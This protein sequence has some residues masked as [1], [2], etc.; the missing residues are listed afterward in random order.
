M[1][2]AVIVLCLLAGALIGAIAAIDLRVPRREVIGL[3]LAVGA[4][5]GI[6]ALAAYGLIFLLMSLWR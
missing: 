3:G 4:G 6:G 2:A 5:A 1:K